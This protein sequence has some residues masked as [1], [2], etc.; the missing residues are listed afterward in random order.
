MQLRLLMTCRQHI[1]WEFTV[2]EPVADD[3]VHRSSLRK[4]ISASWIE[5]GKELREGAK[6]SI[7]DLVS[8]DKK[9]VARDSEME[10]WKNG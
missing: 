4:A 7:E 1:E 3:K 5:L 10:G 8:G 9:E 2:Q 6:S